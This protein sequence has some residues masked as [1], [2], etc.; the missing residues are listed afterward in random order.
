[1]K[2]NLK[3]LIQNA[4]QEIKALEY[5]TNAYYHALSLISIDGSTMA[6]LGAAA[7]RGET[8]GILAEDLQKMFTTDRVG[9]LLH[10]LSACKDELDP[11]TAREVEILTK[12]WDKDHKIPIDEF[13]AYQTLINEADSVW[14]QAKLDND[15]DAFAPYLE[16]LKR[17]DD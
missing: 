9:E 13:V 10:F 17:R 16:K 8:L 12:R 15:Y 7:A 14:H 5:H 1:M 4:V 2:H 6:P 11:A 3:D